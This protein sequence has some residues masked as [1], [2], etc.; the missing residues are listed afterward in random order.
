[1]DIQE[2][3]I[4]AGAID[5]AE[6]KPDDTADVISGDRRLCFGPCKRDGSGQPLS[7]PQG[8]DATE[9][10]LAADEDGGWWKER[11]YT[12]AETDAEMT[13]LAA[14]YAA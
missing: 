3:L 11:G 2:I 13:A 8:W 9:Y 6:I 14:K 5:N 7:P 10:D 4:A 1:M 12:Y